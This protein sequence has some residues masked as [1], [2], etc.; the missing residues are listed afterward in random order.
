M[1][2]KT[3]K[4]AASSKKKKTSGSKVIS[5][6]KANSN[7]SCSGNSEDI[8]QNKNKDNPGGFKKGN[9]IGFETRFQ[10][11]NIKASKYDESYCELMLNYFTDPD[12][13]FPMFEGFANRLGVVS[14]T[15]RE[16]RDTQPRFRDTYARC[17]DI[18]KQK[19]LVGG[20][21]ERF[22]AQIVKFMAIN[23]HGMKEKIEQEFKGDATINV[24]ISFF[25]EENK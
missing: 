4:T 6:T 8:T 9:T 7:T 18:Q 15:L 16:W 14:D 11:G 12:E 23:N 1:E 19:L 3:K 24:N 21:T 17:L 2:K 5:N 10:P 13:V 22:N 20:L 25:D